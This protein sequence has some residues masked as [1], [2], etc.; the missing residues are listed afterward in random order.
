MVRFRPLLLA[1]PLLLSGCVHAHF[2]MDYDPVVDQG[3]TQLQR[4]TEEFFAKLE[5]EPATADSSY[6]ATKEF[7]FKEDAELQTLRTRLVF[8]PKST[9]VLTQL[10]AMRRSFKEMETQHMATDGGKLGMKLRLV[11]GYHAP[12]DSE[13][14]SV[15]KLQVALKTQYRT[16][17]ANATAPAL[18]PSGGNQ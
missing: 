2:I 16:M 9:E 12:I 3:F 15:A 17:P 5:A 1:I 7:Y 18:T 13:F 6:V 14:A 8:E 11:Q 10:D 4:E